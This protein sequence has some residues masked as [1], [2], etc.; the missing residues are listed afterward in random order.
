MAISRRSLPM[1]ALLVLVLFAAL[2]ALANGRGATGAG[3]AALGTDTPL[4][5]VT[6][7]GDR[8]RLD[9]PERAATFTYAAA[10]TTADR[11]LIDATIAGGR[12][13]AQRLVG[14]VDGLVDLGVGQTPP[15]SAGIT[16]RRGARFTVTVDLALVQ[17]VL[18]QRGVARDLW[19]ELGHVVDFAI[20]PREVRARLLSQVPAGYG[21]DEHYSGACADDAERFAESF[22]KWATGDI[23]LDLSLGYKVPPPAVALAAWGEPL[24]LL[25]G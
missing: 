13:E 21:C 10:T 3:V 2:I 4:Y 19:H 25:A 15:G 22:A 8:P 6:G 14:L 11:R 7:G 17:R 12:P 23:G 16:Q 1:L 18:G 9:D 5:D 20:L 24:A